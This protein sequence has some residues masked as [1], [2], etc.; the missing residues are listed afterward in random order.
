MMFDPEVLNHDEVVTRLTGAVAKLSRR[1][2]ADAFLS[3]LST[4]RL[5]WR[6]A[7][8]SYAVF[9]H[10]PLHSPQVHENNE[11]RCQLC[12]FYLAPVAHDLSIINFERLKWG[13]VR[14]DHIEFASFDLELFLKQE[15]ST[16]SI[17]DIKIF[18]ALIHSIEDSPPDT[19]CAAL[20]SRFAK[21]LKSNKAERDILVGIL[22]YCGVLAT[23][24]HKGFSD[25]FV[26][27]T[28]REL[29]DRRFVDMAYP[30][31][32][33][34]GDVGVNQSRLADYFGHVL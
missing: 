30:A 24:T 13:G 20:Q 16:P 25:V 22:G 27:V 5:D 4:R 9:Q 26:D 14:H 10:L 11:K 8:G 34:Q 29:P 19:T 3:S 6:S 32:W 21:L 12:G 33:W 1:V 2:V 7:L 28:N 31:C 23:P 15:V 18:Q 17:E